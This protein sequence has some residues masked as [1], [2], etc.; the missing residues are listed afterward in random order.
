MMLNKYCIK[1]KRNVTQGT[2]KMKKIDTCKLNIY[3]NVGMSLR[4]KG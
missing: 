3:K 1:I 4:G 2:E